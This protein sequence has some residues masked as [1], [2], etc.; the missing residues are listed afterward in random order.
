L[1]G[2][3]GRTVAFIHNI[4]EA[5][6]LVALGIRLVVHRGVIFRKEKLET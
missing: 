4:L 1:D 6:A 3:A 2:R 5:L